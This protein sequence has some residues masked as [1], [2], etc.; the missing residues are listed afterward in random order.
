MTSVWPETFVNN[1]VVRKFT[2]TLSE[3]SG[4]EWTIDVTYGAAKQ[5]AF[6]GASSG[7]SHLTIGH[8]TYWSNL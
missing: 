3:L 6:N 4:G 7:A 1:D 2:Q 5:S 8:S